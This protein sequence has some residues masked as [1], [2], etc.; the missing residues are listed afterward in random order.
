MTDTEIID[1][2]S[3]KF[4]TSRTPQYRII[5]QIATGKSWRGCFC[6][7]GFDTFT[8]TCRAY[9]NKLIEEKNKQQ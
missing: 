3:K 4:S 6:G 9:A 1:I 7:S 5:Y 2:M 8:R